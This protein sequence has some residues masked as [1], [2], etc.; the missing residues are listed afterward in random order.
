MSLQDEELQLRHSRQQRNDQSQRGVTGRPG[1]VG[2]VDGKIFE[3]EGAEEMW[4]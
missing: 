2:N 3:K 1:I 4:R